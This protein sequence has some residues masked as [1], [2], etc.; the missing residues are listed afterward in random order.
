MN[1]SGRAVV[2]RSMLADRNHWT[3]NNPETIYILSYSK[4]NVK[5]FSISSSHDCYILYLLENRG[6]FSKNQV[7]LKVN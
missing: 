2:S 5:K 4:S 1:N 7:F 3:D 6:K